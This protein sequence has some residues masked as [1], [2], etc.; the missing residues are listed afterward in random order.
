MQKQTGDWTRY[1]EQFGLTSA[2]EV[3]L[4]FDRRDPTRSYW[5]VIMDVE[6]LV[7]KELQ[8]AQKNG[9]RYVM[10]FHGSSTSRPGKTTARSVVRQF[11]R[12]TDATPLIERAGC[13]QHDSVF[14]ARIRL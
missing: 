9:R 12:S 14:V 11:M 5:D 6:A 1:R 4:H 7:K 2:D 13:I 3:D 10:F 8:K